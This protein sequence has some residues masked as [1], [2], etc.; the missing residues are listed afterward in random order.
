MRRLHAI[1]P[2][3]YGHYQDLGISSLKGHDSACN[4]TL[5]VGSILGLRLDFWAVPWGVSHGAGRRRL[6][7]C[8]NKQ[9]NKGSDRDS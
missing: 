1:S 2:G 3:L 8:A 6:F 7:V 5:S 9:I 4:L